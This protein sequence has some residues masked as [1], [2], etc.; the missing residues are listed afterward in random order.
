[1]PNSTAEDEKDAFAFGA[2]F[3][4]EITKQRQVMSSSKYII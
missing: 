4:F 2:K 3:Q 1:M